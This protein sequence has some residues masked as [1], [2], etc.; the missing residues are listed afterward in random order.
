MKDMKQNGD[1][2]L[3]SQGVSFNN[4][5]SDALIISRFAGDMLQ[6]S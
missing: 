4:S 2:K 6:V 5:R 3:I 1:N